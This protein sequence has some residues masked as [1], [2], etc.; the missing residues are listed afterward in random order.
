MFPDI[1]NDKQISDDRKRELFW[2]GVG[3]K[4]LILKLNIIGRNIF[5]FIMT[6]AGTVNFLHS[7]W[8]GA[9]FWIFD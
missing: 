7:S 1:Y 2:E 5:I 8:Y 3:I 9:M 4:I 6:W